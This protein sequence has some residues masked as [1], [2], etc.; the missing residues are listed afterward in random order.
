MACTSSPST[1]EI[2]PGR[3]KVHLR[4]NELEQNLSQ[5]INQPTKKHRG[6]AVCLHLNGQKKIWDE[7][8]PK[9][10]K[11][12]PL[13]NL[14]DGAF[15]NMALARAFCSIYSWQEVGAS[16]YPQSKQNTGMPL[17]YNSFWERICS[18]EKDIK[19]IS[20]LNWHN[21]L[22]KALLTKFNGNKIS[23]GT[24]EGTDYV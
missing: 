12:V 17:L 10:N 7:V 6:I 2:G 11:F 15:M 8:I 1:R 16:G 4:P 18:H 22:P 14:V 24:S 3:P 13:T 19:R 20:S 21:H 9:G 5:E 23:P